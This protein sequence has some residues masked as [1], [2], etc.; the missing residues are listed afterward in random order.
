MFVAN[1]GE[2]K[3]CLTAAKGFGSEWV[4]IVQ[5]FYEESAARESWLMVPMKRK[6]DGVQ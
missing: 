3:K 2:N 5:A 6:E 1:T 4:C